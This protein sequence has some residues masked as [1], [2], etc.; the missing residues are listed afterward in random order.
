MS[1]IS[2]YNLRLSAPDET[3]IEAAI[4]AYLAKEMS[5]ADLAITLGKSRSQTLL[6]VKRYREL[7]ASGLVSKKR[8][9]PSNRAYP[10]QFKLEVIDVVRTHYHDFG[11][12]FASEKLLSQHN[13]RV[14]VGTLRRWMMEAGIWTDRKSR[15]PRVYSL[16]PRRPC[17]GELVQIDGSYHQWFEK[18]GDGC[19]LINFIDDATSRLQIMRTVRHETSFD[20]MRV[21]KEYIERYGLPLAL[22][23]DKHSIFRNPRPAKDAIDDSTQFSR[24]CQSLGITVICAESPQAKG[25]VERSF[26]TSQDRFIK[27]MRLRGISTMEQANVYLE[28]YCAEHNKMFAVPPE[29]SVDAHRANHNYDLER[30]L[31]YTR[32]RKVFKDLSVNFNK[33]RFVL[34]DTVEARKAIGKQVTVAV[35]LDGTIEIVLEE[36]PLPFTVF[37]KMQRVVSTPV[38]DRKRLG[39]A[40]DMAKAIASVEPHH[41]KRNNDIAKGFDALFTHPNDEISQQLKNASAETRRRHGGRARG[42]L[43]NHPIMVLY[44]SLKYSE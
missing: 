24:A 22:Y 34:D 2:P 35:H 12:K 30:L 42:K 44:S 36:A 38:V 33:M 18:R 41:F 29:S 16:R 40:L 10:P 5:S 39:S 26:R 43:N 4:K 28:E 3:E 1:V 37:D 9:K 8:G 14:G 15:Q 7:G 27:E 23:S 25:R 19:C 20:Y 13:I 11:P 21:L 6:L 17:V 31:V 32:T